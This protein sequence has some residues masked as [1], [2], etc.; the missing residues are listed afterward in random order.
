[1]Y[2]ICNQVKNE[3]KIMEYLEENAQSLVPK[4]CS[5]LSILSS[6]SMEIFRQVTFPK[7]PQ[8]SYFKIIVEPFDYCILK[9]PAFH[10]Y[11]TR[12][13]LPLMLYLETS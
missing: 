1:M 5:F 7:V 6:K 8:G 12:N 11:F 2:K 10:I 4:S 13:L 3:K 9:N